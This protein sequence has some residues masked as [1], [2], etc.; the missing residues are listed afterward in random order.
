MSVTNIT[1]SNYKKI[2]KKVGMEYHK[3]YNQG[4]MYILRMVTKVK[5]PCMQ[6]MMYVIMTHL[7]RN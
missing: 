6:C 2:E 1:H 5:R 7:C 4:Y 3:A